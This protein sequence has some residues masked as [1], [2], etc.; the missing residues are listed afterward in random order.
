MAVAEQGPWWS[1]GSETPEETRRLAE[2]LARRLAAGDVVTLAGALGTGKTTFVKGLAGGLGADPEDVVSPTFQYVR[3]VRGGRLVLFHVDC[4]RL[5][6]PMGPQASD[7]PAGR[8]RER[9]RVWLQELGL[10]HYLEAGGVVAVEWPEPLVDALPDARFEV[11]LE[12]APAGRKI[13]IRGLG[14]HP[15]R[16]VEALAAGLGLAREGPG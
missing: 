2:Q 1:M 3:E 13:Q 7:E 4:Y 5:L 6:S 16:V 12:F 8:W 14:P 9:A 10:D 15:Q 11:R